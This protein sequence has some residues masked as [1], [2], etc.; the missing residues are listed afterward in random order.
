MELMSPGTLLDS[1]EIVKA[2]DELEQVVSP[3]IALTEI[4]LGILIDTAFGRQGFGL[5]QDLLHA[6]QKYPL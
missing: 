5:F 1:D 2:F 4:V 6:W 3:Q